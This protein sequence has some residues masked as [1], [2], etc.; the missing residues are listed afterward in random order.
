[1]K[2][3]KIVF[4][5]LVWLGVY[6]PIVFVYSRVIREVRPVHRK[7]DLPAILF[8]THTRFRKD[9]EDPAKT[10]GFRVL[11]IPKAP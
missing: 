4:R 7:K 8:L 2:L 3:L 1:M 11:M 9:L 5:I 10:G 6:W